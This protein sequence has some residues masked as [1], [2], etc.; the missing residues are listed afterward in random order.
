MRTLP[1]VLALLLGVAVL[2]LVLL[3]TPPGGPGP[4]LEPGAASDDGGGAR[5]GLAGRGPVDAPPPED[6]IPRASGPPPMDLRT[7]ARGALEVHV[8]DAAGERLDPNLV[9]LDL[10]RLGLALPIPPLAL[11]DLEARTWTYREVP[12]GRVRIHVRGDTILDA[13]GD[14]E[15]TAE[16]GPPLVIPTRP[17]GA[18][19]ARIE[20]TDD[21]AR[22]VVQGVLTDEAG[23]G[24]TGYWQ[25]RSPRRIG[26]RQHGTEGALGSDGWITGLKP[27]RY[28]LAVESADGYHDHAWVDVVAGQVADVTFHLLR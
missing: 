1:L 22:P 18:I 16:G 15:I 12:V 23:A 19:H 2:W 4:D 14:G 11:R 13:S 10:E 6:A 20:R 28:R 9:R 3:R 21:A 27:G 5:V 24:V 17:G 8:V 7:V 25:E 26:P